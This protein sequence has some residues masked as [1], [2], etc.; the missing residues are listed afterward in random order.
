MRGFE[1][2][3]VKRTISFC[4]NNI[5]HEFLWFKMLGHTVEK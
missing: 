2:G 4:L 1:G 5:S 3:H